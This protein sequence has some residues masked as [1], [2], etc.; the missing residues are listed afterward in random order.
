MVANTDGAPEQRKVSPEELTAG[1]RR[2]G[3]SEGESV[4]MHALLERFGVVDGGPAMV[5]HRLLGVLGRS[6]TLLMPTFTSKSRHGAFHDN[7]TKPGCWCGGHEDRHLPFI[8]E[9]QPDNEMGAIAHRLCSW[10]SSRRSKHPAYSFVA[11]GKHADELVRDYSLEEPLLPLKRFERRDPLV[12]MVGVGFD[13]VAAIHLAVQSRQSAKLVR[14]RALVFTS[15][16]RN[17]V[18]ITSL[19]CSRG[20]DKIQPWLEHESSKATTIGLAETVAYPMRDLIQTADSVLR[21]DPLGLLCDNPTCLSCSK[22]A[23]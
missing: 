17:W 21:K 9:L 19:G 8:P 23:Q 15:T 16:G 18:D 2:L 10:P 7:Y 14:E 3:L 4:V 1:F 6:G 20:F 12:L 5:L 22:V 13:S 11:V